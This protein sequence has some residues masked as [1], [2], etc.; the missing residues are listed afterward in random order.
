MLRSN[1]SARGGAPLKE[2]ET[3]VSAVQ[4]ADLFLERHGVSGCVRDAMSLLSEIR[5]KDP[6]EFL[7]SYF[8]NL[9]VGFSNYAS[10]SGTAITSYSRAA[11]MIRLSTADQFGKPGSRSDDEG[12]LSPRGVSSSTNYKMN[13]SAPKLEAT[14][15]NAWLSLKT[16]DEHKVY[17]SLCDDFPPDVARLL[18]CAFSSVGGDV[19][20]HHGVPTE[21]VSV[22]ATSL[23]SGAIASSFSI[24]GMSF[25]EFLEGIKACLVAQ[26]LLRACELAF[27]ERD[28]TRSRKVLISDLL[29]SVRDLKTRC[30]GSDIEGI[31]TRLTQLLEAANVASSFLSFPQWLNA[32]FSSLLA[33][34]RTPASFADYVTN[35]SK[36]NV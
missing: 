23:K 3:D 20:D 21:S 2:R 29:V 24:R 27:A 7:A 11:A 33:K 6:I 18:V 30:V 25:E 28:K 31:L 14:A 5:P 13:P 15:L 22:Y 12:S 19:H 16:G 32:V 36:P 1:V 8:R 4:S 9:G 26:D 10:S 35:T 17:R 34:Q